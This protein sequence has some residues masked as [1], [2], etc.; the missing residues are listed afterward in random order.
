M[1]LDLDF[2]N[3]LRFDPAATEGFFLVSSG[4]FDRTPG[5]AKSLPRAPEVNAGRGDF[6]SGT[7]G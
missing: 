7:R 5:G 1:T 3:P 4:S 2:S 6:A